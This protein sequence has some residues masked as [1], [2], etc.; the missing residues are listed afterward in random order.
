MSQTSG[1][2]M[3][4]LTSADKIVL[5]GAAAYFIWVFVP[6]W[7]SAG[8]E[9][10]VSVTANGFRFPMILAW[11]LAIAAIAELVLRKFTTTTV[12]LPWKP[13]VLHLAIAGAALVLTL[14]GLLIK[15]TGFGIGW[16][17][18]V[19]IAIAAVWTYG[20]YMMYSQPAEAPRGDSG[21]VPPPPAPGGFSG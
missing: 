7:Y 2:D 9:G 14:L 12:N 3:T 18:F 21:A 13:G 17:L 10:I 15:P 20:A 11:L 8:I 16:A 1:F 5:G 4:K 19:G 6:G